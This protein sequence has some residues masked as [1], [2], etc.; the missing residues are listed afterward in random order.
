MKCFNGAECQPLNDYRS[1]RVYDPASEGRSRSAYR[2]DCTTAVGESAFAGEQCEHPQSSVCEEGVIVSD[3]AFCT[4]GGQCLKIV[5]KG[6]G[7]SGCKCEQE[8][9][10]RHCQYRKGEAPKAELALEYGNEKGSD[11]SGVAKFFTVAIVLGVVVGAAFLYRR[12]RT[13]INHK[14]DT[15]VSELELDHPV[16][17][18]VEFGTVHEPEHT[19]Y[20]DTEATDLDLD[21]SG[22]KKVEIGQMS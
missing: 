8:Y 4:N 17:K 12:R 10:G 21:H 11:L 18:E 20:S 13:G 16:P 15:K 1:S 9:E 14:L 3:Y 5:R 2:C 7:H 19:S 22:P 6:E